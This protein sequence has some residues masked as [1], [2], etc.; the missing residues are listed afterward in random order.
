MARYDTDL[1]PFATA[2]FKRNPVELRFCVPI[3]TTSGCSESN[4][5]NIRA[6]ELK[7]LGNVNDI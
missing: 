6:G 1:L 3:A 7:A 4:V 2:A 5:G